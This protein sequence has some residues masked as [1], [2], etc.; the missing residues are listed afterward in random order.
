MA[1]IREGFW[2]PVN[3]PVPHA[4]PWEGKAEFLHRLAIVEDASNAVQ[5]RGWSNCRVCHRENGSREFLTPG[6]VWPAGFRHYI[7]VHNVR[8][9]KA[10][11]NY[12]ERLSS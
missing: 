12:I 6:A 2:S 4:M 10:F 1:Q 7:E 8:P 3:Q 5:Y 11:T 9:S